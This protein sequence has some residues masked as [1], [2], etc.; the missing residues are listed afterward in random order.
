MINA[1]KLANAHEFIVRDLPKGYDTRI[2]QGTGTVAGLSGGQRQR[3][4]IARALL[5]NAP[6]LLMDEATSALDA[7]S[8]AQVQSA[9][10]NVMK[11]MFLM[12]IYIYII[13][14]SACIL[15]FAISRYQSPELISQH[16]I[17]E[18]LYSEVFIDN[19]HQITQTVPYP[20]LCDRKL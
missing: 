2:G 14:E 17:A 18:S 20:R 19:V 5:K 12:G 9:L 3:I 16:W 15:C 1:A 8:E 6:I 10:N 4:A 11:S 7:E 13:L